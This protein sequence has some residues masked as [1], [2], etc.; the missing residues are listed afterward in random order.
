[1][2]PDAP[3]PGIAPVIRSPKKR[4]GAPRAQSIMHVRRQSRR[5]LGAFTPQ[6]DLSE[7]VLSPA[8]WR[9]Y[10]EHKTHY[11]GAEI[12]AHGKK[13]VLEPAPLKRSPKRSCGGHASK[14][15]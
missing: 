7:F 10:Q 9:D 2:A 5:L 13:S 3:E 14:F 4:I 12:A 6:G 1:M 11:N 8:N 15:V